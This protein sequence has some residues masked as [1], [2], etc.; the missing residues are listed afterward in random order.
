MKRYSFALIESTTYIYIYYTFLNHVSFKNLGDRGGGCA[1]LL[2][3]YTWRPSN[4][5]AATGPG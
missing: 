5:L 4:K 1:V 3:L 2:T